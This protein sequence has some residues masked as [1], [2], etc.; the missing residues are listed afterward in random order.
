MWDITCLTADAGRE[1]T[2][3][4][5]FSRGRKREPVTVVI[6][7]VVIITLNSAFY[8]SRHPIIPDPTLIL[9]PKAKRFPC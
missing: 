5:R 3:K 6:V 1:I 8:S 9:R 4:V 2:D 7:V